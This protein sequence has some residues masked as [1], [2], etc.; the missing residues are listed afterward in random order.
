MIKVGDTVKI[1]DIGTLAICKDVR[2]SEVEL[3]LDGERFWIA[4]RC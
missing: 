2:R 3:E 1:E 4:K